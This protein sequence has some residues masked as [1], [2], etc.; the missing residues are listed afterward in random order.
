MPSSHDPSRA[1]SSPVA[2]AAAAA[3]PAGVYETAL[4]LRLLLDSTAEGI[5]GIDLEGRCTFANKA[6]V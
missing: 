4:L 1:S 5:Y 6:C 3:A 2:A